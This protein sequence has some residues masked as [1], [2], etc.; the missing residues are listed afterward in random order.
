MGE[1]QSAWLARRNGAALIQK[2]DLWKDF[3]SGA[4]EVFV[5]VDLDPG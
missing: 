4:G 5:E 3:V 2:G 1:E